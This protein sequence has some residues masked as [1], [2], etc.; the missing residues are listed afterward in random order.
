MAQPPSFREVEWK[1]NNPADWL[2]RV[3]EGLMPKSGIGQGFLVY[4]AF[5]L[6][7]GLA[8]SIHEI[9]SFDKSMDAIV[10]KGLG[11]PS[12]IVHL[13]IHP[14]YPLLGGLLVLITTYYLGL[15]KQLAWKK[16]LVSRVVLSESLRPVFDSIETYI[17]SWWTALGPRTETAPPTL[18]Y[19]P[20]NHQQAKAGVSPCVISFEGR[21]TIVIPK[22]FI[23]KY[24]KDR[25]T[26]LALLSHELGHCLLDDGREWT[27]YRLSKH[28]LLL[29]ALVMCLATVLQF[30]LMYQ[31][32]AALP[33]QVSNDHA[34]C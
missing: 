19:D 2:F 11:M 3:R 25:D 17:N 12:A 5:T 21:N 6:T 10:A 15:R 26:A 34:A 1:A 33:K 8:I 20:N 18:V 9:L 30:G 13:L 7:V 27:T 23:S 32:I 14:L 24:G 16:T 31:L 29:F 22:K 4:F 28:P